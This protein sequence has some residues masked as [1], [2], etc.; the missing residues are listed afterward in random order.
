M[1]FATPNGRPAPVDPMSVKMCKD[2][3]SLD[4]LNRFVADGRVLQ[5]QKLGM[6][7]LDTYEVV[8]FPGG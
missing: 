8:F 4:F 6:M 7:P 3:E 5:C 1:D 2:Q